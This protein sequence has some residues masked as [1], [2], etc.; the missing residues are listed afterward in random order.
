M[1]V[2]KACANIGFCKID[3]TFVFVTKFPLKRKEKSKFWQN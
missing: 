3:V 1:L 2:A